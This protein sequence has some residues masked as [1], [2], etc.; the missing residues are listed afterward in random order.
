M[1]NNYKSTDVST[2]SISEVLMALVTG[3]ILDK[4][5]EPSRIGKISR[6]TTTQRDLYLDNILYPDSTVF[7]LGMSVNL[8]QNLDRFVWEQAIKIVCQKDDVTKTRFIFYKGEGFQFVDKNADVNFEFIDLAI[9][10]CYFNSLEQIIEEKIKTKLELEKNDFFKNILVKDKQGNY[11]AIL[12][13]PHILFDGYSG[14][15]FFERVG[16]VYQALKTGNNPQNFEGNSFHDFIDDYV[17]RFDTP[18]IQQYWLETLSNVIPVT[19]YARVERENKAKSRKIQIAGDELAQIRKY[20]QLINCSVPVFFRAVY[21]IYLSQY[22]QTPADFVFYD[23]IGKRDKQL[24]DVLG[25]IYQVVPVVVPQ[26]SI[27]KSSNIINYISYIKNYRRNLDNL[28]NISVLLQ[29]NYLK[30]EQSKFF[31]N[32][33]NFS[34]LDLPINEE[35]SKL[36]IHNSFGENEVHLIINDFNDNLEIEL[37]YNKKRFFDINFLERLLFIA[38]QVSQGFEYFDQ[39]NILPES[40][41]QELVETWNDT[42]TDYA[43]DK[44]VHQLF[45]AQVERSPDAVAVVFKEAQKHE[46]SSLTYRELN[47]HANQLA[48]YLQSL[49]VKPDMPVGICVERTLEMAIAVLAVLKTGGAYVPIDPAYP[50]ERLAFMLE[51]TQVSVLLT[52]QQLLAELP[53]HNSQAICLDTDWDKISQSS[54]ENLDSEVTAE[55]LAYI[56]YTSGSTGRP[57]GIC[58][59]HRPLV[60]LLQ[61]HLNSL[62][63]GVRTLQFASLSFDASFHE[64]FAAWCS[65]GTLFLIS[66]NLRRDTTALADFIHNQEI[67]KVIL[68]VVVLQQMAELA[69]SQLQLFTSLK[70]VTTTGEQLQITPAIVKLFKSLPHCSFH[71]HYGPSETHVITALTLDRNPDSWP[72]YPSIG[73]PIANTQLYLLD[74]E[75]KPV[76]IGVAGELY[77]GG[78]SLARGYLN[79]PDLTAERFISNPYAKSDCLYKTGD[80]ACYLP[81]GN[82]EYLGRI[83]QQVKIRGFRIELGEIEAMLLQHPD[84]REAAVIAREDVSKD[85]RLV[86]YIVSNLIPERVPYQS[87]CRVETNDNRPVELLTEDIS[88]SGVC[89]VGVPFSWAKGKQI[90]I[91]LK[92]PMISPELWLEGSVAWS[93]GK[94]A[95]INLLLTPT[96]K[97]L[98]HQ[99]IEHLLETQHLWKILQRTVSSNLR[100]FLKEK[101]PDYMVPSSFV[102]LNGLP[103]TPNGKLNR[104]ALPTPDRTGRNLEPDFVSPR[105]TIEEALA[106]IWV[107]VL[108]LEEISVHDNFFEIGGHSLLATQVISRV[109]D[110]YQLDLPLRRLF[111][112]PTVATLAENIEAQLKQNQEWHTWAI[113]PVTRNQNLPLSFAQQRLWFLEQLLPDNPFYNFPQTFHLF[114]RVNLV[115][116]EQS[117]N[118]IVRR[119]EVLRTTFASSNGQPVQIIAPALTVPLHLVDLRSRSVSFRESLSESEKDT[120]I[121]RLMIEEFQQPFNINCG[122]L[123]R[124]TLLQLD[125][126]EYLLLL[127]IHHIVFDGWSVSVLFQELTLLYQT[128]A[129]GLPSP[130]TE[131]PIQYADFGVWQRQWLQEKVISEQLAYWKQQ[132]ADL[133]IL[134]LPSVSEARRR[135]RPRPAIQTYRGA[136][137]TLAFSKSLSEA[138]TR[139]SQQQGV[140]L[141]MTLLAAFQTLL[142]RYTS[143]EDI[144]VGTLIANRHHQEIESLIGF[145]VNSLVIRSNFSGSPTFCQLLKQVREV[146]LEAYAHQDLPFEKLV[147]EL[148]PE[149]DLSRH[150]LFQICFALQNVPMQA[151]E[152]SGLSINH[153]LEHNGTAKF[154]LFLEL[155]ETPDGISGWFEYSTDLFDAATVSRIGEHFQTLVAGIVTNP[156]QKVADLPLLTDAERQQLLVE[157]NQT[158][159]DYPQQTC[160]HQ[161]FEAQVERSPDS[162]AAI[163]A[164]QQ[165]TYRQLNT[166]ANQLARHLQAL[167]VGPDVLVGICVERSLEMIVGVLAIL[168][169]GGAYIPLDPAYPQQR[170][171]LMLSDSQ[172]SVLLTQQHLLAQLPEH[173][174]HILCLDRD[175]LDIATQSQ[176]NLNINIH[177]DNLAYIIYTSGSTGKPKGVQIMHRSVV[178]FLHFM[179]QHL[180]LTEQDILLSV[181]TLSFDI[182]VLEIFLPITLGAHVLM[183]SREET[184]DGTELIAKL[185]NSDI[186]IM[187]AT[188]ATWQLLLEAGWHGNKHLKILCGGEALPRKL[189]KQLQQRCA[190]LWNVYGPTETTIWSATYKVVSEDGQVLIG[191]PMANTEFYVLDSQLQPVP[192][193]VPGELYIGGAGLA[194]GYLNRPDLTEARFLPNPFNKAKGSDRLYKTGDLV[195]YLPDGNIEYFSRIDHQVKIRGFRIELGEIETVLMQHPSVKTGV[196]IDREDVPGHKRLVA[197]VVQNQQDEKAQELIANWQTEHLSQWQT[198]YD[199]TYKQTTEEQNRVFNTIGWNSSY[200]GLPIPAKEMREWVDHTIER[201][202]SLQPSQVLEIGCGTGLLLCKIISCCSK[203]WGT[204]FAPEALRQIQQLQMSGQ[205]WP[206]LTLLQRPAD[207]FEGIEADTFN[208]V[209]INSVVQYFPSIDYLVQVLAGAVN[210]VKPG[211]SIFVGDVRSLPLLEAYHA[212]VALYQASSSLSTVQIKERVRQRLNQEEELVIHPDFF[213]ALQQHLPKIGRVEIQVKRGQHHNELTKFRYDVILHI[214]TSTDNNTDIPWLDWQK[215]ELTLSS[216]RHLL[217][218]NQPEILGIRNVPNTRVIKEVKTVELLNNPDGPKTVGELRSHLEL[219]PDTGIDPEELWNLS[220]DLPYLLDIILSESSVVDCYEVVFRHHQKQSINIDILSVSLSQ[221]TVHNK[222]W[223]SYANQPLKGKFTRNLASELCRFLEQKLPEYMIPTAFVSLEKLPLTP[224][225]KLDRR[226][227]PAPDQ[228]RHTLEVALIRPH[229]LTEEKMIGIWSQILGIAH[230]RI[231]DN[232]FEL[233]GNSLLAVQLMM[234]VRENFQ[235]ELPVRYIFEQQTVEGLSQLI[236][237]VH[238]EG[239]TALNSVVNLKLEAVLDPNIYPQGII[240]KDI[241]Q[242]NHILLTGATGFL[243]AFLIHE[244]LQQTQAKIYC[245][246]RANNE[247]EGF[248]RLQQTLEKY[249]IWDASQ[250]SRIIPILGDLALLRLGLSVEQFQNLAEQIDVI[251]HSGAQV[252]FAKPYSVIKA[253][254]VLGTQ[255]V[256]RLACQHQ[257]KPVHYISTIAVFGTIACLTGLNVLYEDDDIDHSETYLYQ[258]IGY[259]QSKWVAEKLVWIAKSRGIPVTVIRSGFLMGHSHTGVTNT[260]DYISRLIKGC[261]QLGSFPDLVN[262]KQDLIT[263]DYAS[264]TI[265][266]ISKKKESLGKAFHLVPLASENIDLSRLF[267]LISACGYPLK[268]VSY[269][270]WTDELI[271]QAQYCQENSLFPLISMLTEQVHQG[272]T[273]WQLYQNTPNL[274]CSNTLEAIADI[275]ISCPS[276]DTELLSKYLAYFL[277]SGFLNT[278]P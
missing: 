56:I 46:Q 69:T 48:H 173:Q 78:H 252:N 80:L 213:I 120:E 180:E 157:W 23:I 34:I 230:V 31:Y 4:P 70:E 171:S 41:R 28:Q 190:T 66:E 275:S 50:K 273:A 64:M 218:A 204:D 20:C 199:Q 25:C 165:I 29:R 214:G 22:L 249:L 107:E 130:L 153:R 233:G 2:I 176:D 79:R 72:V 162:I 76:P 255:E 144:L 44:C 260:D 149:R 24:L 205:D 187:Q 55:N 140:T 83:D 102:M 111:D 209:I 196:V 185:T 77:I 256:L 182:A 272:L 139:F 267:E 104:R 169:A 35:Y 98:F 174:A 243:G 156:D 54:Q 37:F 116:L 227:L 188:P 150:P 101:L 224:N 92:L 179:G 269:A 254:N 94:R 33:Y 100:K 11:T 189:A 40:E 17:I 263:V 277:D 85:K 42:S 122:P 89:L 87:V 170:L 18:D 223:N 186:T 237:K 67:E 141:Y 231:Q 51:D 232:F 43:L 226:A 143:S 13:A 246:V 251:Y 221:D 114:G 160:I 132:L 268:K 62:L 202:L 184:M 74:A 136:R 168:K 239:S 192:V 121:Q 167:G 191:R 26:K 47:Q 45:E 128:F 39:L 193:G 203:Y 208:T 201:I 112:A 3:T 81:D 250:S 96:E 236:D 91:C 238:Q 152:L 21:G 195:R 163:F 216:V 88:N 52:Q 220:Q 8:L 49:G 16:K 229:T 234:S 253:A 248:K 206:Q 134:Q 110:T 245:L 172:V 211:G 262:Q 240:T 7:T 228:V 276:M 60:N 97:M 265:V 175:W 86:G 161:L 158:Q 103:L 258:D 129:N 65:G 181:T 217:L 36:T 241:T 177:P 146:T 117:I 235:I 247:T 19:P 109:R 106:K 225:G 266:Q 261:I 210:A 125:S 198:L 133:P 12:G 58:L 14:K 99:S 59:A 82:I 151:L 6:L 108:R 222:P 71:N 194:R 68:P 84:V 30:D 259:T 155:F 93:Q 274:D 135:H 127:S 257:L 137:Q 38:A 207:N 242:P 57:K 131:L 113:S 32:F 15:I 270:Q 164:Q 63:T 75:L 212:S 244:L 147:E 124:T 154:D 166:R 123:L 264:K 1:I 138:V 145:F 178:N 219:L 119:H 159:A 95:G 105:T 142:F 115:A 126:E 10:N 183:V 53:K 5:C 27:E 73:R 271:N 9:N 215:Q 148:E 278:I 197:Y 118:E 200:T 90:R 61:W